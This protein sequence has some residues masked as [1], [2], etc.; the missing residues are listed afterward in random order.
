VNNEIL[1]TKTLRYLLPLSLSGKNKITNPNQ[2]SPTIGGVGAAFNTRLW[3]KDFQ[4]IL[5]KHS[6]NRN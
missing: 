2:T 4:E 6:Y 1:T 5:Q 3:K